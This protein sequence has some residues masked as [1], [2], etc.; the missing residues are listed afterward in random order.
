MRSPYEIIVKPHITEKSVALSYG[1]ARLSD[2]E[3]VRTYTFVVNGEANKFE[4]KSALETIY[5]ADKKKKD[6]KIEVTSV[7]TV[8]VKG[9][10]RRVGWKNKGKKPDWKKAYITLAK[11]QKLEDYGV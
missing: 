10:T 1:S 3:N 11:G 4:I 2:E 8:S 6:E 7:R 5:N 9:K